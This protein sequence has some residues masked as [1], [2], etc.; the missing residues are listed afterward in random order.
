MQGRQ[1]M[2]LSGEIA[3]NGAMK[4]NAPGEIPA[5][6]EARILKMSRGTEPEVRARARARATKVK[7][8]THKDQARDRGRT[9][10]RATPPQRDEGERKMRGAS[11]SGKEERPPCF[12]YAKGKCT[13]CDAC[14][15]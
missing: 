15:Y 1:L 2:V 13:K 14:D 6:G 9:R 4:A 7:T 10:T 8:R 12:Q 3:D 5:L 11:P